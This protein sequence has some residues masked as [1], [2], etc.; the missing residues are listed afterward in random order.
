[1]YEATPATKVRPRNP[2]LAIVTALL[3]A[4]GAPAQVI[5]QDA[6]LIR[7][8][9]GTNDK[10]EITTNTSRILTL[11]TRIPRVQVNNPE[12]LSVTALSATQ[13]QVSAKKAGVTAVNLWD[14]EGNI[15][16]VDVFIYGDVRELEHALKT[17]FPNSSV[18]VYRYSNSLVLAGFI[19]RPDYVTPIVELAQ[20]YSPKII[21]NMSVGGVQQVLLKVKVFEVSRT[22][23]R[24]L[25]VDWTYFGN[26]GGSV[27]SSVSDIIQT[28][29]NAAGSSLGAE[30]TGTDTF[31]YG[32]VNGNSSFHV[33]MRALQENNVAKI[34]AEPNVVA[35]S[36]RP[37]SFNEGG[38]IPILV[39]QSLGTSSIEFKPYG[40]QVDFLPIV[41]GNG[42]IRLEVRPRISDLDYANGIILNGEQVPALKVRE[43]DTAV[44][45]RAGQTFAL[46]GLIQQRTQGVKTGLPILADIPFFGVPFRST[47]NETEEFE[48]LVLATPEFVDA[49][50]PHQVPQ[51][52][53]GSGTIV[54]DNRELYCEGQM[55]V[56][57]PCGTCGGYPCV[58]S[59]GQVPCC[60]SGSAGCLN[61]QCSDG[62]CGSG[63]DMPPTGYAGQYGY[64]GEY[65]SAGQTGY[66]QGYEEV[67]YAEGLEPTPVDLPAPMPAGRHGELVLPPDAGA[68]APVD[69]V[70]GPEIDRSGRAMSH[71]SQRPTQHYTASRPPQ[72]RRQPSEPFNPQTQQGGAAP[73]P[74]TGGLIGPVGYDLE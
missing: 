62:S 14:E 37:A 63:F 64:A 30:L 49:L 23:L 7:K 69:R 65:D 1:M 60:P 27:I 3:L 53:P 16:T 43:V 38:E 15:H 51:C 68:S 8:V 9:S 34:M 45:L 12:L 59:H 24:Q 33:F 72:Y 52:Y 73:Q 31:A 58:P 46:A 4:G 74:G 48:L 2:I 41:L 20:D 47:R 26:G 50:D 67:P 42:N 57:N 66:P 19:D 44:E 39:P 22:K 25:G 18:R 54:P 10:L 32:V 61:G 70:Q 11:E 29:A 13:I 17:Q 5:Q 56:P 55:E 36:G 40:T 28:T 21:N 6:S 35:V 71:L